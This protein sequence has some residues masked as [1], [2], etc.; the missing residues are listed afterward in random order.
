M[1]SIVARLLAATVAM[2]ATSAAAVEISMEHGNATSKVIV[3]G[4]IERGDA[5]RF[6]DFWDE[7]AYDSF[8]FIVSLD[9]PGGSLMDG[10]EIGQFIRKNGAHTEV[11]RY[12]AEVAGQYYREERPGAE[13]YSACALAFMGGVEREVANDGKIGFHQFYGG[14]STS[15]TEAMETTQYISAFLAGYLRDMGAK[16]ELFER[17]SGT[18][19]DNMFVPSAAQLSALNIVPQ[20][21]FHEFKL[22]PKDGLIV[23]TAVNERNPD[24]LERLYEIETL[25]WKKRPI[26]NLYAADDKQGLSPEMASRST[27]H[28][29]GFRI[30]TTAGSYEYG[31]D[32]IRLYPNQRLLASLVIDPKVARALGG[33]NGMVVVNSYTASGV[34]I[35]GRIEAPPG[36][37]EAILASFRDCL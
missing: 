35:S 8:R 19:P 7:N 16:P 12:S 29:D 31:K 30:D 5:K 6:K 32:S 18:S 23:A 37:D 10:I 1:K 11:R 21:G 3:T 36:G 25:C 17:L 4:T 13:C 27:T 2:S 9:S 15:A 34:F 20:L 33:G 14:S 26:I 24:A 22:M 28:I